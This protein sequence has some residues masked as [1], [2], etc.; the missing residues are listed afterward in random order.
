MTNVKSRGQNLVQVARANSYRIID[1]IFNPF[2]GITMKL[3]KENVKFRK[4]TKL[5]FVKVNFM[6]KENEIN[7]QYIL[8]WVTYLIKLI[9]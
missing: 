6:S 1:Q 8:I 5:S 7:T 2:K 9:F 4:S 3:K